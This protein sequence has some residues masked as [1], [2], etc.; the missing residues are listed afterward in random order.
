LIGHHEPATISSTLHVS[1]QVNLATFQR[2]MILITALYEMNEK[3]LVN[4]L[5]T[6]ERGKWQSW[7][8]TQG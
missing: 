8:L 4:H 1:S 2:E 7:V 5:Q 3:S 6:S